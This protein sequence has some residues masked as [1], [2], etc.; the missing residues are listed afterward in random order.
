MGTEGQPPSSQ[1]A[2]V[3]MSLL[4]WKRPS[5]K[6]HFAVVSRKVLR[7]VVDGPKEIV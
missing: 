1:S 7:I 2:K 4:K 5:N 3:L 6:C